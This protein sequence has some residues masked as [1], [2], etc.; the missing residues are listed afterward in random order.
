MAQ[1]WRQIMRNARRHTDAKAG[2]EISPDSVH[3][4]FPL[5]LRQ[6]WHI[7]GTFLVLYVLRSLDPSH[8]PLSNRA[9]FF[10]FLYS[11]NIL[12]AV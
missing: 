11:W 9:V 1:V 4:K 5:R 3:S 7:L 10:T 8:K 12:H 6:P 2:A